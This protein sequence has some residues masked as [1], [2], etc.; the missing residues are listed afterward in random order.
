MMLLSYALLCFLLAS[1]A[2]AGG[3]PHPGRPVVAMGTNLPPG[4]NPNGL[5][6]GRVYTVLR[7]TLVSHMITIRGN[8]RNLTV[9]LQ[10]LLFKPDEMVLV[11]YICPVQD[12]P[13]VVYVLVLEKVTK[14]HKYMPEEYETVKLATLFDN[15]AKP[16][17]FFSPSAK[18]KRKEL[19]ELLDRLRRLENVAINW[20]WAQV[21][22][23]TE[24]KI[25]AE[26][27][28][29]H[30][31]KL[32]GEMLKEMKKNSGKNETFGFRCL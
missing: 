18:R 9:L 10:G 13:N 1:T 14:K 25:T 3:P 23:A 17:K 22:I 29:K 21:A 11:V 19:N 15:G 27:K 26:S 28:Q 4:Y 30:E 16:G 8:T 7:R 6:P 32:T 31:V 5:E 20:K 2:S 12:L 24:L